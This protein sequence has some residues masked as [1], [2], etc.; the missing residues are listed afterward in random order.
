MFFEKKTFFLT[1]NL[2][3]AVLPK[4]ETHIIPKYF[5]HFFEVLISNNF[6][7]QTSKKKHSQN[8]ELN[9]SKIHKN[10]IFYYVFCWY[11][12]TCVQKTK[13]SY[14]IRIIGAKYDFVLQWK[15]FFKILSI[16]KPNIYLLDYDFN[17][18]FLS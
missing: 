5:S 3:I 11:S 4:W 15:F 8:F 2:K 10:L 6:W 17:P 1:R 13:C 9:M 16:R 18:K 14:K 12:P 7:S